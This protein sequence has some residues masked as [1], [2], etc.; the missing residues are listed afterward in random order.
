MNKDRKGNSDEPEMHDDREANGSGLVTLTDEMAESSGAGE[1]RWQELQTQLQEKEKEL[2]ELKDKYLRALA[3]GEN[4][5][6]RIR[7]QSEESVRIQKEGV[8]R[9]LLPIVDNL[10]RAIGAA[11]EGAKD[12]AVIVDG[13]QM[14]LRSLLDFLKSQGVVPIIS[15]GQPFD[16]AR[17]EAVDHIASDMHPPNTVVN[18]FHR[19]Y[20]IG[21]R[22]LRPASVTVAKGVSNR[23]N[24]GEPDTSEVE[25]D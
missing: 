8:L 14:V 15:A 23:R 1:A 11:R 17:H 4:A 25:N 5:R 16:P 9:D 18:E 24:N 19:G 12:P 20:L 22:V 10:E 21:D 6:K 7:Q 3:D 13:V 2:A